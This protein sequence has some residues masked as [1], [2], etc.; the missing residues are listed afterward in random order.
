MNK[1]EI[2]FRVFIVGINLKDFFVSV[3]G[4]IKITHSVLDISVII[5]NLR[6]QF[7]ILGFIQGV[8]ELLGGLP[9][10]IRFVKNCSN[11]V[12]DFGSIRIF[13]L[14]FSIGLQSRLVAFILKIFVTFLNEAFRGYCERGK[15]KKRDQTSHKRWEASRSSTNQHFRQQKKQ[16]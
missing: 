1:F 16:G 4:L 3:N 12:K 11:I 8:F 10:I 5:K 14:N 13:D 9:E 6:H 7:G 2:V 15:Q